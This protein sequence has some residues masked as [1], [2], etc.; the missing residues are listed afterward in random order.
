M[1]TW[2][3][4]VAKVQINTVNGTLGQLEVKALIN[5]PSN[6]LAWSKAETRSDTLGD[7]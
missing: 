1:Y 3:D 7:V 2:A 4:T 5:T 6:A